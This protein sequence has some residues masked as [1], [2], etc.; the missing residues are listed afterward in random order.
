VTERLDFLFA[1]LD[2]QLNQAQQHANTQAQRSGLVVTVTALA[3]AVFASELDKVKTGE[4]IALM[5]FAIA[6]VVSIFAL[7]PAL[8]SGPDPAK[9]SSWA[10]SSPAKQAVAALYDAKVLL[11]VEPEPHC[12]PQR[13]PV[14]RVAAND[15]VVEIEVGIHE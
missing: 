11:H 4:V 13:D 6:M 12:A 2:R 15:G 5:L 9:L 10:V 14:G 3:A 8:A 7:I 1:E